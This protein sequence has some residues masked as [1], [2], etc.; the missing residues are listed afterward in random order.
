MPSHSRGFG[1]YLLHSE[2]RLGWQVQLGQ[3]YFESEERDVPGRLMS[4][5]LNFME[6][7]W[8]SCAWQRFALPEAFAGV[9]HPTESESILLELKELYQASVDVQC[10]LHPGIGLGPECESA[11]PRAADLLQNVYWLRWPAV[12]LLLRILAHHQWR[13]QPELVGLLQRLFTRT[14]DTKC[15]E[16]SHKIGRGMEQRDQ[17]PNVLNLLS[18][19]ST[20]QGSG[21]PLFHRGIPHLCPGTAYQHTRS[22]T[23]PP[24]PWVKMFARAGLERLPKE[25]ASSMQKL[26]DSSGFTSYTPQSGRPSIMAARALVHIH[27]TG[28]M[29][30]PGTLSVLTWVLAWPCRALTGHIR[31]ASGITGSL[32]NKAPVGNNLPLSPGGSRTHPG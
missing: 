18:F 11:L 19:Y 2:G 23:K 17:S 28:A 24:V 10:G 21:T 12:D 13:A 4:F 32:I 30:L 7:R 15:V 27:S 14:G 31:N 25:L 9:L 16:E 26:W 29:A 1:W 6:A 8:W 3:S 20:L 5:L 22:N